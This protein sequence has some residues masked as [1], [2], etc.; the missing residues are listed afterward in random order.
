[1]RR[2]YDM[3]DPRVGLK[4]L[5]DIRKLE[6]DIQNI[7]FLIKTTPKGDPIQKKYSDVRSKKNKEKTRLEKQ[8]G[9]FAV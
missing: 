5:A 6:L 9:G 3:L 1:M 7:D 2:R 4:M 8:L